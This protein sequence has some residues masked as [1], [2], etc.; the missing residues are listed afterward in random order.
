MLEKGFD[1]NGILVDGGFSAIKDKTQ[2]YFGGLPTQN[3]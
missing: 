3:M 1:Q 2:G